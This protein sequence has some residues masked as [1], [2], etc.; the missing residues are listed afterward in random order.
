MIRL[1]FGVMGGVA[2]AL[3]LSPALALAAAYASKLM[4]G[5]F[6]KAAYMQSGMTGGGLGVVLGLFGGTW[7]VLR[8]SGKRAGHALAWLWVGALIMLACLVWVALQ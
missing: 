8:D 4:F 6:A 7:L 1:I 5:P 2:G 3:I